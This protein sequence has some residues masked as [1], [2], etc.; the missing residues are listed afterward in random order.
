RVDNRG[1]GALTVLPTTFYAYTANDTRR[2]VT[3]ATYNVN[4]NGTI[5]PRQLRE[6]VD[7]KYRR[8]WIVPNMMASTAQY[9]GLNWVMIRYSDVLLMFAEAENELNNG[10]TAAAIDAFEKVRI[11]AFGGN[12]SLIGTT[13]SSYDG[14]FNAIV[15]ERMLELCGEGVR[16][17]DLI[18][19]NLLEQRLAEVKQQLADMVAGLPPYDNLPTTMYFTPG[20]TTMTWDNSLY[21]PAPVTPPTGS[22]A[23]AW[24]SSTIQTTLIDVLAYGFEPG[25]DEL[26]PFHTTTIDANPKIIQ[27][28]GY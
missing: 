1:N 18:R 16:K 21:D 6:I 10:P 2:D 14:F 20:I 25:K 28:N 11:R 19:W 7:G 24:T 3:C 9:F 23:V 27:N 5:A 13:P 4:A 8:D 15:N 12:A 17:F 26:L 22:T